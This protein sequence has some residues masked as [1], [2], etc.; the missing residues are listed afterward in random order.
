MSFAFTGKYG[1]TTEAKIREM[2]E[3]LE[4]LDATVPEPLYHN[5][6]G[7]AAF[8][9]DSKLQ[10]DVLDFLVGRASSGGRLACSAEAL[11]HFFDMLY[12]VREIKEWQGKFTG[13]CSWA[14]FY[15]AYL[16]GSDECREKVKHLKDEDLGTINFA[17]GLLPLYNKDVFDRR[18]LNPK[19]SSDDKKSRRKRR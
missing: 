1:D 6:G 5:L 11:G 2:L 19:A 15:H 8:S 16:L 3:Y 13:A 14:W 10:N 12:D 4:A 9:S 7:A 18:K 17:I